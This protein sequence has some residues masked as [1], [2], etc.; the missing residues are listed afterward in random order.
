LLERYGSEFTVN[1]TSFHAFPEPSDLMEADYQELREIVGDK[2]ADYLKAIAV[3]FQ[4]TSEFFMRN[5]DFER[6]KEWLLSIKGIGEWSA[7]F[8]LIRG[9]GRMNSVSLDE[10]NLMKAVS[11]LYKQGSALTVEEVKAIAANY[12]EYQGYWAHY[13]RVY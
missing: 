9:L 6:V 2:R 3:V 8:V 7:Q 10:K 1:G 12:C 4:Q 5:G 13:V 11:H